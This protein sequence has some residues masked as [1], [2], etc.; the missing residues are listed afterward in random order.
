LKTVCTCLFNV[1]VSVKRFFPTETR[2]IKETLYRTRVVKPLF[3]TS[4]CL[5]RSDLPWPLVE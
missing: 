4:S 3:I 5:P 1:I 2:T